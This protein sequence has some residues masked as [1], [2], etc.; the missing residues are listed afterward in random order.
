MT[1]VYFIFTVQKKN[2]VLVILFNCFLNDFSKHIFKTITFTACKNIDMI[3]IKKMS[4]LK[5]FNEISVYV[6]SCKFK[7]I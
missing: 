5:L 3:I 7:R 2:C 4:K 6:Y 1:F